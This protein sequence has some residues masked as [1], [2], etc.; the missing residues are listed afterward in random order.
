VYQEQVRVPLIIKYPGSSPGAVRNDLVSHVDLLPTV[1]DLLGNKI[2]PSLPGR[3]LRAAAA[4]PGT[5]ISESFPCDM[6]ASLNS[7]FRRVERAAFSGP[8][9]LILATNGKREFYDL[10]ADPHEEHN[11]YSLNLPAASR[12]ESDLRHWISALPKEHARP[13]VLDKRGV[14]RLKSLGYVQ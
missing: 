9:K 11:L 2:P 13:A 12:M 4:L 7:R 6:T 1:L 8:F 14:D 3:S 10:S 5:V